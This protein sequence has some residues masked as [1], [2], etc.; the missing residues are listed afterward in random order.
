MCDL[1]K[2]LFLE[3]VWR[4][5]F[6]H[7]NLYSHIPHRTDSEIVHLLV[8]GVLPALLIVVKPGP[9]FCLSLVPSVPER[10]SIRTNKPEIEGMI[11]YEYVCTEKP[12]TKCDMSPS[13]LLVDTNNYLLSI[14]EQK[15]STKMHKCESDI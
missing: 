15:W 7:D 2:K 9:S 11:L 1:Q 8:V 12:H 13:N 14:Y 5:R 3:A 4:L 10:V 6:D